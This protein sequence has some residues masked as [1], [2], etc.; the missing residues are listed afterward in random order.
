MNNAWSNAVIT[1]ISTAIRVEGGTGK[2][3][4]K[5]RPFHGLV[6][7]L[8]GNNSDYH[9]SDG[10]VLTTDDRSV[11]YLPKNSDYHIIRHVVGPCYAI[12]FDLLEPISQEPFLV[13]FRSSDAVLALFKKAEEAWRHGDV[14][15]RLTVTA[16]VCE[17]LT[18]M[19]EES[20]RDYLP[21]SKETLLKPAMEH[22]RRNFA[23]NQLSIAAL[24][25]LCGISQPYFRKLFFQKFGMNPKAHVTKLRMQHARQLLQAGEFPV[26]EIAIL[27]GYT[28][29]CHFTR[30]FTKYFGASPLKS[31]KD[32]P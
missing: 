31:K 32:T 17:I 7:N 22:L 23:D 24:A 6:I 21:G 5:N 1:H 20:R 28:E 10:T 2:P 4:H 13:R 14:G 29:A 8:D 18:R 3:V 11:F 19:L 25:Q 30:E 9:F 15:R 27:C 16:C 12:N 26:H